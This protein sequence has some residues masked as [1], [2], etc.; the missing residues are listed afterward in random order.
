M[1]NIWLLCKGPSINHVS[2]KGEGG[3]QIFWNLLSRKTTKG[4]GGGS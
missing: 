1:I 4:E 3:G 2:S